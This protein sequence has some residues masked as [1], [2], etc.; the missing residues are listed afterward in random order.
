M[1]FGVLP[2]APPGSKSTESPVKN[3]TLTELG[4]PF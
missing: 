1:I 4:V 2:A 3:A